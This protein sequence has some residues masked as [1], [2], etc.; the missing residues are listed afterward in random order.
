MY[1]PLDRADTS[2]AAR[3]THLSAFLNLKS[4]HPDCTETNPS[5][6][7]ETDVS[8][9]TGRIAIVCVTSTRT[10]NKAAVAKPVAEA[11]TDVRLHVCNVPLPEIHS[12]VLIS[13]TSR[14]IKDGAADAKRRLTV[15][16][17]I[18]SPT[19]S[20]HGPGTLI[21]LIFIDRI[22]DVG[23]RPTA[24]PNVLRGQ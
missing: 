5:K 6:L 14:R 19:S 3:R 2:R 4:V 24:N 15:D 22:E 10:P 11:R 23:I 17:S 18:Y 12:G 8:T 1:M 16:S 7:V 9:A 21:N 20:S 13:E